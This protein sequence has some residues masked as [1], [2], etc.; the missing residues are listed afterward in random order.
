MIRVLLVTRIYQVPQHILDMQTETDKSHKRLY[1][2]MDHPCTDNTKI[3][4]LPI[5]LK[6]SAATRCLVQLQY[7][8]VVFTFFVAHLLCLQYDNDHL[9]Q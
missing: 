1:H 6:F 7:S 2:V 4:F 9:E 3:V 5:I 8:Q